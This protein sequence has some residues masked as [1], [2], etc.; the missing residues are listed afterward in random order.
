LGGAGGLSPVSA[1]PCD[2]TAAAA[3]TVTPDLLMHDNCTAPY[4]KTS[5]SSSTSASAVVAA[6]AAAAAAAAQT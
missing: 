2:M 3:A 6:A 1:L 5:S 4:N